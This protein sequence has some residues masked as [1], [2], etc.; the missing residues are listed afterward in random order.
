MEK[1]F[2]I[3]KKLSE[4][5]SINNNNVLVDFVIHQFYFILAK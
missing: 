3:I 1:A 5:V 2:S 4:L